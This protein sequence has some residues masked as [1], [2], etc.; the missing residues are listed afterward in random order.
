MLD[1]LAGLVCG[2]W[3]AASWGCGWAW[4]RGDRCG[5]R[6]GGRRQAMSGGLAW[7]CG[8]T[9]LPGG[10]VTFVFSD[11]EGSTRLVKALREEYPRVLGVHRWLVRSAIAGHGGHEV[12]T[13][14]DA[15]SAASG[16]AKQAVLCALEIQ[17]ALAAER[18]TWASI[19]SRIS[20][21]RFAS[22]RSPRPGWT[23]ELCPP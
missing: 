19:P 6:H 22:S 8:M 5:R 2:S 9:G 1:A 23:R 7:G 12:D 16:G 10:A 20:I 13:R 4:C 11:I 17:R 3:R 21:A 15:F 14:G 18:W